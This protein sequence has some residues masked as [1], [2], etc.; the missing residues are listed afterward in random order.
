V[1]IVA[2]AVLAVVMVT[3]TMS[4]PSGPREEDLRARLKAVE[5]RE[6]FLNGLEKRIKLRED[7]FKVHT[8]ITDHLQTLEVKREERETHRIQQTDKRE[9]LEKKRDGE[10]TDKFKE[11]FAREKRARDREI[12]DAQV[13]KDLK[14]RQTEYE[15]RVKRELERERDELKREEVEKHR[16]EMVKDEDA[17]DKKREAREQKRIKNEKKREKRERAR[18][19]A[20]GAREKDHEEHEIVETPDD[21]AP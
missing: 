17:M 2:V 11:E 3:R 7:E 6:K 19:A 9:Q 1:F 4:T 8:G 20:E 14:E 12:Q 16:E 13:E 18:E 5:H 21:T 15:E 10:I